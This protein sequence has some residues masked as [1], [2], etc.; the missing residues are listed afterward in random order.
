MVIKLFR[1]RFVGYSLAI[2]AAGIIGGIAGSLIT[3]KM[4]EVKTKPEAKSDIQFI[5]RL[6]T[7]ELSVVDEN[8]RPKIMLS[9]LGKGASPALVFFDSTNKSKLFLSADDNNSSINLF[10]SGNSGLTAAV[11]P[12]EIDFK[13]NAGGVHIVQAIRDL[14][15]S[16]KIVTDLSCGPYAQGAFLGKE[17]NAYFVKSDLKSDEYRIGMS[18]DKEGSGLM[19]SAGKANSLL[20]AGPE[21]SSFLSAEDASGA[22]TYVGSISTV[23][24]VTG[25][26]TIKPA[27]FA[28]F[29]KDGSVLWMNPEVTGDN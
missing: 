9:V 10:G 28:A 14:K 5:P 7:N 6:C 20:R 3:L 23:N 2:F 17:G 11:G 4:T 13:F 25:A 21:G 22:T 24:K 26:T 8:R 12:E 27:G 29:K 19:V 18:A 15:K 1:T 16:P